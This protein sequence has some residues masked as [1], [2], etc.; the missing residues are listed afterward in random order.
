MDNSNDN[1][2]ETQFWLI[3]GMAISAQADSTGCTVSLTTNV[4][5]F[6]RNADAALTF[7]VHTL[8][9]ARRAILAE[10]DG[11]ERQ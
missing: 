7:F 6:P 4:G 3:A 5:A 8:A 9:D 2:T 10:A 1:Q 11:H